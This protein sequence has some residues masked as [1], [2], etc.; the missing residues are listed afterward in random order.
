MNLVGNNWDDVL[1]D[2]YQK[3]Y[4]KKIVLYINKAYKER[5]IF[6]HK[7]HILIEYEY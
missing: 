3:E 7:N 4:F 5:P 1:K 2:E 6:P